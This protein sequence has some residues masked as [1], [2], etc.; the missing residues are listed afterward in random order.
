MATEQRR[1]QHGPRR[2]SRPEALDAM[3]R[4]AA[5]RRPDAPVVQL[6]ALMCDVCVT[7]R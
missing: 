5:E 2:Q 3:A 6:H 4:A 1:L 7:F